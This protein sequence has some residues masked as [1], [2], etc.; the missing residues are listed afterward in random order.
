M[1]QNYL[2]GKPQPVARELQFHIDAVEEKG[3]KNFYIL[4]RRECI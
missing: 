3:Y 4:I 2:T 1:K